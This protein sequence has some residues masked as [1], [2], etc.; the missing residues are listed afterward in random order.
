L[1]L[2][3]PHI[4]TT[5]LALFDD[6]LARDRASRLWRSARTQSLTQADPT[7]V[8]SQTS[9]ALAGI[10]SNAMLARAAANVNA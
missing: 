2:L 5:P 6:D 10:E 3:D 4:G 7:Q 9:T 1:A 8:L